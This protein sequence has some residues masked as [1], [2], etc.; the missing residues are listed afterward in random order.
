MYLWDRHVAAALLNCFVCQCMGA[1]ELFI[2]IRLL[3]IF[4]STRIKEKFER[5]VNLKLAVEGTL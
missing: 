3:D 4:P 1:L 5:G 2:S